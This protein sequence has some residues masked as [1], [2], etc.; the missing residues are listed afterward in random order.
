MICLSQDF[1]AISLF[2]IKEFNTSIR[3]EYC[4]QGQKTFLHDI[5][6]PAL[7]KRFK[8]GAHCFVYEENDEILGCVEIEDPSHVTFLFVTQR[9][10]RKGLATQLIEHAATQINEQ[11]LSVAALPSKQK[12]YEKVGFVV[13]DEEKTVNSIP[14]ILMAK[15]R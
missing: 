14:F 11:F 1:K 9:R 3:I 6:V 5:T 10:Q 2:M 4:I 7:K 8:E 15:K 12:F 13:V